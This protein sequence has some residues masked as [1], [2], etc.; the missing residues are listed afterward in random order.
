[1][2]KREKKREKFNLLTLLIRG[3]SLFILS[4]SVLSSVVFFLPLL[5]F[6]SNARFI[7][8]FPISFVGSLFLFSVFDHF[9]TYF[10]YLLCVCIFDCQTLYTYHLWRLH[11][12]AWKAQDI[13]NNAHD[14]L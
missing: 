2:R 7:L 8:F 10:I 5:S 9:N 1:M 11:Q 3:D 12:V 4:P 6:V 13:Q 14:V